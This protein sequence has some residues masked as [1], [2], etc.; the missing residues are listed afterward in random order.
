MDSTSKGAR[1]AGGTAGLKEIVSL[2]GDGSE[3]APK[4]DAPQAEFATISCRSLR[5]AALR[6]C[7]KYESLR[8]IATATTAIAHLTDENDAAA[9]EAFRRLWP[10]IKTDIA[11]PA[12]ELARLSGCG[13]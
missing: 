10:I 13:R 1:H 4:P 7:L 6:E 9:I 2:A 11:I 12:S 8:I 5:A 3:N